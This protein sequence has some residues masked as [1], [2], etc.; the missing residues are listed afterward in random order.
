MIL[1]GLFCDSLSFKLFVWECLLYLFIR[2]FRIS[3]WGRRPGVTAKPTQYLRYLGH[4]LAYVNCS[5]LS[6][7]VIQAELAN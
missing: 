6:F 2:G 3:H 7:S 1:T 4:G 5:Q